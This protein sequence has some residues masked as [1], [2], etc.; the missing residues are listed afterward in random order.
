MWNVSHV[1]GKCHANRTSVPGDA[2]FNGDSRVV[3]RNAALAV[4]V[5]PNVGTGEL[6]LLENA[7]VVLDRDRIRA[8]GPGAGRSVTGAKV[9]DGRGKIVLPGF[10]D[11]HTHAWQS[12]IRG[13]ATDK[14]LNGWLGGCVL[15]LYGAPVTR[16]DAYAGARLSTMDAVNTGVT[17]LTDWSHAFN[18]DFARGNLQA[19][20]EDI[21]RPESAVRDT[22]HA[23]NVPFG[24][25]PMSRKCRSG[26]SG[27][28]SGEPASPA[29][30]R[31]S[32]RSGG[33]SGRRFARSPWCSR[34]V[35]GRA[36]RR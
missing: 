25:D 9:I 1:P 18:A 31:V 19:L 15:P 29:A 35:S 30:S 23:P 22:G 24:A 7:D 36:G 16:A 27:A 14:E 4:T 8:V 34:Q 13:C 21:Q 12:L 33:S 32:R 6:G 17:T 11:L 5:D 3:I 2:G 10:V 20:E 26:R 28:P